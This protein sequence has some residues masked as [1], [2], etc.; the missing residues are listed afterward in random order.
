MLL[1]S[2]HFSARREVFR[3]VG[4]LGVEKKKKALQVQRRGA[5]FDL[6]NIVS[7]LVKPPPGH[8]AGRE[9]VNIDIS[10]EEIAPLRRHLTGGANLQSAAAGAP[11]D[12]RSR[13]VTSLLD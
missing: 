5:S 3:G 7:C 6:V 12:P 1:L 9:D 13:E 2:L 4:A 10:L 11:S 8:P